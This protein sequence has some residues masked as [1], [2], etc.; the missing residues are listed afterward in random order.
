MCWRDAPETCK[1]RGVGCA[2]GQ[3]LL[4]SYLNVNARCFAYIIALAGKDENVAR[5][6]KKKIKYN[7]FLETDISGGSFF[8]LIVLGSRSV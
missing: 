1:P 7:D 5:K 8:H 4:P 3:H 2:D 6:W